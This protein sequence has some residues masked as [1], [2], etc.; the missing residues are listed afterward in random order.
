MKE[1][2]TRP[3][4]LLMFGCIVHCTQRLSSQAVM[5]STLV[6][7]EG[8]DCTTEEWW[9]DSRQ[10]RDFFPLHLSV[11][12]GSGAQSASYPMFTSFFSGKAAGA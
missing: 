6:L 10:R 8:T 4:P 9:F 12:T 3:A 7:F 5:P 2:G 11:Q 1:V